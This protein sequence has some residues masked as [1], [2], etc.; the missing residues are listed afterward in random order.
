MTFSVAVLQFY[1]HYFDWGLGKEI[2]ALSTVRNRNG[3]H[4]GSSVRII[5]AEADLYLAAIDE[6]MMMK[7]GSR[8]D[9]SNLIPP[10]YKLVASGNNYAVWDKL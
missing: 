4:P 6:K 10:Q 2:S 3:I 5:K 9:L 7:I 1:D 8:T